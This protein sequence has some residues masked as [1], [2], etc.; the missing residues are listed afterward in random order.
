MLHSGRVVLFFVVTYFVSTICLPSVR[1]CLRNKNN[2]AVVAQCEANKK[3]VKEYMPSTEAIYYTQNLTLLPPTKEIPERFFPLSIMDVHR[4][5]RYYKDLAIPNRNRHLMLI[6]IY[7]EFL[8][9]AKEY[10][11]KWWLVHGGLIGEFIE[12]LVLFSLFFL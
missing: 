6:K 2:T 4:D 9:F 12:V 3:Y 10:Q 11:L 8:N 7:Q 5:A 1:Q